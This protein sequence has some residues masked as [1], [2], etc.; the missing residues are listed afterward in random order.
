MKLF[1]FLQQEVA[2]GVFPYPRFNENELFVQLQQVVYGDAP[3]MGPSDVYSI[4][5][6]QFINSW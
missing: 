2:L 4:R 1:F 6:V 5:T 3:I